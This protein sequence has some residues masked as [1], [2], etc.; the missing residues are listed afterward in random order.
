MELERQTSPRQNNEN[1]EYE[2]EKKTYIWEAKSRLD[3]WRRKRKSVTAM[4]DNMFT[5]ELLT[6]R[7]RSHV[8]L[9]KAKDGAAVPSTAQPWSI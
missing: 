8:R 2:I 9:F 7:R 3:M 4:S 6:L 1:T 5:S